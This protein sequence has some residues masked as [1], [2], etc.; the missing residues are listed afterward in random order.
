MVRANGFPAPA[1]PALVLLLV[2]LA[3]ALPGCGR[4]RMGTGTN[5]PAVEAP[6]TIGSDGELK[7]RLEYIATS[8]VAGSGLAGLPE[9]IE[10]HANKK[11]LMVEYKKL[12]AASTP[13]QIKS[14]A[15]A[16]LGK[17]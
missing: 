14:A 9:C 11:E 8:G 16:M 17:L 15:K 6:P 13:D 10:K 5:A 1:H 12:Q 4:Y 7:E 2:G 3:V